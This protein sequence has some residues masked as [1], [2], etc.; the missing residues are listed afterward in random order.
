MVS[1]LIPSVPP[2][3]RR[4]TISTAMSAGDTP[5]ILDACPNVRGLI[6]PSFLELPGQRLDTVI[7][8]L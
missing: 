4:Y 7:I 8:Q 3:P 2:P 5:G 6:D 1:L